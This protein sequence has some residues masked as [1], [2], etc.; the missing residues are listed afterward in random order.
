MMFKDFPGWQAARAPRAVGPQAD[1]EALRR[2]YLEL[3]KLCLC[4]LAGPTTA[5]VGKS[6]DGSVMSRELHGEELRLRSAGMDWPLQGLT[7]VGLARLD[8]LQEC[9]ESVVRDGVEG[10]LIEA[11]AWRGG[12][13]ILMRAALD[14]LGARDRTVW[15]ADSFQGFPVPD[16][17]ENL[18]V[19]D[20]LAVPLEEVKE[21]FSRFGIERGVRFVPGFFEDTMPELAG[22]RWSIVRLDGDTYEAT[23]VTLE[24]LYPGLSIGGYLIVDDYGALEE[25]RRAV[26]EFRERYGMTEPLEDVDWTGVR[27]RRERDAPIGQA[28]ASPTGRPVRGRGPVEAVTRPRRSR[29]PSERELELEDEA[30]ALQA[31][32]A[33]A[34]AE[35]ERLRGS[36]VAGPKAWLGQR[37]RA[38]R[39]PT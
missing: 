14:S 13:S 1:T 37:L 6:D 38:A 30:A 25:C 17:Q 18:N 32:L 39:G 21:N 3:L 24:S 8:D 22:R 15:V 2:A 7:M 29:V 34:E 28:E 9:V 33:A 27:W 11:G 23:R 35:V 10:D 31:R 16:E 4:D 12:A 19:V 5:S 20:F 26:D 36:P